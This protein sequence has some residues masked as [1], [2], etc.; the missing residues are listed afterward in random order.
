MTKGK[1]VCL[2]QEYPINLTF[3]ETKRL[4]ND[5][6]QEELDLFELY[7]ALYK[8]NEFIKASRVQLSALKD[9]NHTYE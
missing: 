6:V 1:F 8:V 5:A 4:A 2:C 9:I 7:D 3:E